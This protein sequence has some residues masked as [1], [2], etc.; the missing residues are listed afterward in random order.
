MT[1]DNYTM[2]KLDYKTLSFV[3]GA[4]VFLAGLFTYIGRLQG[5]IEQQDK[6]I[7]L[8]QQQK[9]D[10]TTYEADQKR[11]QESILSLHSQNEKE[12]KQLMDYLIRIESKI[13]KK[14]N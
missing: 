3:G 1:K 9:L 5:Q 12:H 6:S 4:I 7:S 11:I 2:F 13:D 8:L 10:I 14:V